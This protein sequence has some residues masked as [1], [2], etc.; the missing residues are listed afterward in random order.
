MPWQD[1]HWQQQLSAESPLTRTTFLERPLYLWA[2]GQDDRISVTALQQFQQQALA[3]GKTVRLWIDP[4]SG[5]Q[6]GT[7][8]SRR[9]QFYL[10]ASMVVSHLPPA[11]RQHMTPPTADETLNQDLENLDNA[12]QALEVRP[13]TAGN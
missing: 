2:A 9:L 1:R 4:D 10:A 3:Q 8:Q 12:L 5:H 13:V 11:A 6:A 7:L